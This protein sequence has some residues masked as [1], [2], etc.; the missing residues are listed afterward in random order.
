M[1]RTRT[2]IDPCLLGKFITSIERPI[3]KSKVYTG[4]LT[5]GGGDLPR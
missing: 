2:L 5:F 1:T 4:S 3:F